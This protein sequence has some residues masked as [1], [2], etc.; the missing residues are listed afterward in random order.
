MIGNQ[1][2]AAYT[3]PRHEKKVAAY[4]EHS[5]I[6]SFLPLYKEAHSWKNGLRVTIE[7]PLFPSYVFVHI[8]T[9]E[10]L[11][12]VRTPSV[13]S[14]VTVAGVPAPLSN[15]EIEAL[16]VGVQKLQLE[17]HPYLKRGDRVRVKSGPLQDQEGTL[18][19]YKNRWRVVICIDLL[20]QA[21]AV[22]IE[23][24]ELERLPNRVVRAV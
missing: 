10:T 2:F 4:L 23:Q 17:P 8:P 19:F 14:M 24:S 12:V 15:Q 22:E 20:M 11:K 16:R 5:G 3:Y 9:A 21:V 7:K 1:W 13:A 18:V 6:E